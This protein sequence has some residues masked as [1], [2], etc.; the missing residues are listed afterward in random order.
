[1][2]SKSMRARQ[3]ESN[4]ESVNRSRQKKRQP[5]LAC[6]EHPGSTMPVEAVQTFGKKVSSA[7]AARMPHAMR[8]RFHVLCVCAFAGCGATPEA[9]LR[10][11]TRGTAS[12]RRVL[13]AAAQR[14]SRRA[15]VYPVWPCVCCLIDVLGMGHPDRCVVRT[16]PVSRTAGRSAGVVTRGAGLGGLHAASFGISLTV[17]ATELMVV[18]W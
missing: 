4:Q 12:L 1:M 9:A 10:A 5:S 13:E 8:N 3:F 14:W 18:P 17:V 6:L 16:P 2:E 7:T 11:E 15:T